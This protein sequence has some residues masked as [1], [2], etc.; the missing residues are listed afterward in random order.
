MKILLKITLV[1]FVLN[2][3]QSCSKDD[4]PEPEPIAQPEPNPEPEP[5]NQAPTQ[6]SLISPLIDAQNVDVKPTFSWEAATDPDGDA[7]TY[8]IYADTSASPSTQI[9]TTSATSFELEERL[10]LLENYNWKVVAKDNNNGESESD[11][12]RFDTRNIQFSNA[13]QSADFPGRSAFA[14][15]VFQDKVWIAGGFHN[16]TSEGFRTNDI[17]NSE[18]GVNWNR[19]TENAEWPRRINHA[20]VSFDN[21]LWL[22][23]GFGTEGRIADVWN[24]DD[25]SSWNLVTDSG[26]FG[27]V[28]NHQVIVFDN[29]MW[30]TYNAEVWFSEDG[31][32][33]TLASQGAIGEVRASHTAVVFNDRMWIIGELREEYSNVMSS[34]DGITWVLENETPQ[35][36][37]DDRPRWEH[38]SVV[39]DD[40]IWLIGGFGEAL[41]TDVW[42]SEDGID[43][44]LS[45][46][47]SP[48]SGRASHESVVFNNKIW[49]I[50]GEEFNT[51]DRK[52]DV[53]FID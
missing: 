32:V 46:D 34:A 6:V 3:L 28:N 5:E 30:L 48:Y 11:E 45:T 41:G 29:K 8:E 20:M 44:I 16:S 25:G 22:I 21:K 26:G 4:A 10:S 23:G 13:T 31:A 24:S 49:I 53:W 19:V 17:W 40:K 14:S 36:V 39:F 42:Y 18:D 51:N 1:F 52:N 38:T 15:A 27:P 35:F 37:S 43:W 50:G 2:A 9:G 7:I 12:Q 47:E 33:W